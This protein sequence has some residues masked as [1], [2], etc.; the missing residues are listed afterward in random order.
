MIISHK[1]KYV[2]VELPRT[3]STAINEELCEYYDGRPIL[4]KHSTYYDFLKIAKPE[5]REYFTFSCIRNPLDDAV[6][7]YFKLRTNH[8]HK[9]TNPK[10]L[11][12]Q[13]GV[14]GYID[15]IKYKFI[16]K[17]QLDFSTYFMRFYK[18][19]FNNWSSLSHQEMDF[20]IK[21]EH[22]QNDFAEALRLIG[23]EPVRPLPVV[24]KTAERAK[25]YSSY[26]NAEAIERAKWVFGPFMQQWGYKFPAEW[27]DS[28]ITTW[29]QLQFDF[30]NTFRQVY[31]KYLRFRI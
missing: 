15:K 31:W 17:D 18:I 24:N 16:R 12:R 5:E 3:G 19:P 27:G 9:W 10:K 20:V 4:R 22:L 25:E 28:S 7:L 11:K 6:S 26:Y 30:F 23:I 2:F 1:Y 8:K 21:F 13:K 14:V 29:N